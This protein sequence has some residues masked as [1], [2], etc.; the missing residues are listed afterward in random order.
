MIV[1]PP[2]EYQ[3]RDGSDYW[4]LNRAVYGLRQAPKE[5]ASML[6]ETMSTLGWK[7]SSV[8]SCYYTMEMPSGK[9]LHAICYVDDVLMF[10]ERADIERERAKILEQFPR[11]GRQLDPDE[12]G[13]IRFLGLN[14]RVNREEGWISVDQIDMID[15]VLKKF[16][17][18]EAEPARTPIEKSLED[19]GEL[20]PT[21]SFPYRAL[22]GSL[23]YLGCNTRPD[24]SFSIK[25]LSRFLEQP[26]TSHVTAAKRVLRWLKSTKEHVV[27]YRKSAQYDRSN[28]AAA[29]EFYTDSDF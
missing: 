11:G 13:C 3:Q 5:W 16:G 1:K 15:S 24:C 27:V 12:T 2:P 20:V 23:M 14:I 18:A 6:A 7:Q 26:R 4:I 21:G 9:T 8:D 17:M 25:E 10:G 28:V 19:V 22:V 29:L